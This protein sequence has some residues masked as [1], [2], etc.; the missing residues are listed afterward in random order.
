MKQDHDRKV[1]GAL[2]QKSAESPIETREELAKQHGVSPS[3][4]DGTMGTAD[5]SN[6]Q[7][8]TGEGTGPR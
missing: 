4:M 7:G 5:A 6:P 2:A 3:T 8:P 1:G